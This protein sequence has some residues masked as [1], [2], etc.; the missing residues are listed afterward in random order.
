MTTFTCSYQPY[1]P[2]TIEVEEIEID[3]SPYPY[4]GC[5]GPQMIRHPEGP[6]HRGHRDEP[7]LFRVEH[8]VDRRPAPHGLRRD[9]LRMGGWQVC[10]GGAVAKIIERAR[11]KALHALFQLG[12]RH[13]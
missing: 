9:A 3:G 1:G 11:E 5:P 8:Q 13:G 7:S 2:F 6:R 10:S 12:A 4:H